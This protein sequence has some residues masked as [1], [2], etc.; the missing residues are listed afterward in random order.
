M[1][2]ENSCVI[3]PYSH[4]HFNGKHYSYHY[5]SLKKSIS[6]L[7]DYPFNAGDVVEIL[8]VDLEKRVI[9]VQPSARKETTR[10]LLI[11]SNDIPLDERSDYRFWFTNCELILQ[12]VN[13]N[14]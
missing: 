3:L 7:S 5:W 9:R 1:T 14:R 11:L 8:E 4:S 2:T 10:S 6:I 13:Q 12:L